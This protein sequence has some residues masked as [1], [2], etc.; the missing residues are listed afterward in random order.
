MLNFVKK[1]LGTQEKRSIS[2][3]SWFAPSATNGQ[4]IV[5][6]S[7]A[8]ALPAV[9]ACVKVISETMGSLPLQTYQRLDNGGRSKARQ[10]PN[11]YLLHDRPN[12]EQSSMAF[13]EMI[14]S[15]LCLWGWGYSEIQRRNDGNNARL[16]PIPASNVKQEIKEGRRVFRLLK[17]NRVIQE[18]DMVAISNF[19]GKSPI[20]LA[21]ETISA[22]LA[23]QRHG[24]RFF[25]NS[26]QNPAHYEMKIDL[27]QD[28]IDRFVKSREKQSGPE[29]SGKEPVLPFGWTRVEHGMPNEDAQWLESRSFTRSEIAAIF[30]CP[31]HLVGDLSRATFSNVEQMQLDFVQ[32]CIRPLAVR[33]E[34]EINYK[35]YGEDERSVFYS[36]FNLDGLLRGDAVS[37]AAAFATQLQHGALTTNEWRAAE[38][39]NPDADHGDERWMLSTLV[40]V[41]KAVQ[42]TPSSADPSPTRSIPPAV[43]EVLKR[44]LERAERRELAGLK[45]IAFKPEFGAVLGQ[46]YDDHRAYLADAL[47]APVAAYNAVGGGI[48]PNDLIGAVTAV[49]SDLTAVADAVLPEDRADTVEMILSRRNLDSIFASAV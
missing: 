44:E 6:H 49:E 35:L 37:R 12:P 3:D 25:A 32:H 40:P 15:D 9:H 46:F 21:R 20:T 10:H 13:W 42:S 27:K 14:V 5:N 29:N 24:E 18:E 26:G 19:M 16:W 4:I 31:L 7:T 34:Q 2:T 17:E 1:F 39:R 11:Y 33:I 22:G 45:K 38:N 36:E 23:A 43:T 48:D 41:S 8:L 47:A 28:A 30:R